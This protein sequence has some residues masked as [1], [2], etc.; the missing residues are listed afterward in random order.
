MLFYFFCLLGKAILIAGIKWN[1]ERL[2]DLTYSWQ[3]RLAVG[4]ITLYLVGIIELSEEL[5]EK[6][7]MSLHWI[8]LLQFIW[9]KFKCI[10]TTLFQC[11]N[12]TMPDSFQLDCETH[13]DFSKGEKM[14]KLRWDKRQCL[15]VLGTI[16]HFTVDHF[17]VVCLVPW[18]L[19]ENEAG[20]DLVLM[21]T[22]LFFIS[23][24][25]LINMRTASLTWEKEGGFYQNKVTSSLTFIQRPG[26]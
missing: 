6:N 26:N 20:V 16:E 2:Y 22:S 18:P 13:R 15:S 10:C 19:N 8:S 21:E 5:R 25:P 7:V 17:T 12:I 3:V 14:K 11:R 23:K 24:F 4:K 9:V 1:S